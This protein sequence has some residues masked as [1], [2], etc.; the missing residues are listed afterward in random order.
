MIT[1]QRPSFELKM[2]KNAW[3][4]G[5]SPRTHGGAYSTPPDPLARLR[6]FTSKGKGRR[7]GRE[8]KR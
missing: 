7:E 1:H 4:A 6:G 2:H 3:M 5:A 8:R